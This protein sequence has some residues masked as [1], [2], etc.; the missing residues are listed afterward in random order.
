M[1]RT[2]VLEILN[3]PERTF[4]FAKENALALQEKL[5]KQRMKRPASLQESQNLRMQLNELTKQISL[6]LLNQA[7]T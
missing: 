1:Q 2:N 5:L 4:N 3:S 7:D 6:K